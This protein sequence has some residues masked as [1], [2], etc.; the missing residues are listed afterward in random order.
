MVYFG[1]FSKT[2]SYTLRISYMVLPSS[3][4]VTFKNLFMNYHSSVP[5]I[6]QKALQLFM[7]QGHLERHLRKLRTSYKRKH[8]VLIGAI[9]HSFGNSVTVL[10]EAAGLHVVLKMSNGLSENEL[11][12]RAEN[13]DFFLHRFSAHSMMPGQMKE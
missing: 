5:L 10:E 11:I 6:H 2:L 12:Q 4:L 1:T 13:Y 8:D 7:S 3:P 9:K